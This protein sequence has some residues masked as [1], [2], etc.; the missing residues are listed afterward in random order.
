MEQ[1]AA[2]GEFIALDF[3]TTG[4]SADEHKIIE[5]GAIHVC[6]GRE[7]GRY[8]HLVHPGTP[9]PREITQL[10]GIADA[11]VASAPSMEELR[12]EFAA[13]L[14]DLPI[15]A[16]NATFELSF[17]RQV[18]G[19]D[20]TRPLLDSYELL[21]LMYPQA[22]SHSLEHFS[23]HFGLS[24]EARHRGLNDALD[25]VNVV[26]SA[27]AELAQPGY[28]GLC[29]V[30]NS[31]L[32]DA[33]AW[34]WQPLFADKHP[35]ARLP[36]LRNFKYT[37]GE[38][39]RQP[40]KQDLSSAPEQL[41]KAEFFGRVFAQYEVRP[42]QGVLA[43]RAAE[44]LRDGGVYAAEAGTGIGKTMAY[45]TAALAALARDAESPV[46]ITTHTKSL[47]NQF[48]DRELPRLRELFGLD[49][50]RAVLIKGMNNYACL[51][52]IND[53]VAA[54]RILDTPESRFG[55]AFL[56]HW[57]SVSSEG[58]MDEL[59][60]S[61]YGNSVV[62]DVL[63]GGRALNRDC[64]R[65]Q[66]EF[67]EQCFYFRKRWEAESAHLLMVNHS[68]L[69]IW[70]AA[71]PRF[72]RLIADEA[73]EL[74]RE[75][76]EAYSRSVAHQALREQSTRL[77]DSR[78][79]LPLL[80]ARLQEKSCNDAQFAA[81]ADINEAMP[82]VKR[83]LGEAL[84]EVDNLFS[85]LKRDDIYTLQFA[86]SDQWLNDTQRGAVSECI[87]NLRGAVAAVQKIVKSAIELLGETEESQAA[88]AA[89]AELI[90]RHDEISEAV[91]TL[92]DYLEVDEKRHAAFVRVED[93]DWSVVVAPFNIGEL[94]HER[95]VANMHGLVM[96][97]A[98]LSTRQDMSDV[99]ELCGLNLGE[100]TVKHDRFE[101]P[102][103]YRNNAR[104]VFLKGFPSNN[105]PRFP[106]KAAEFIAQAGLM[107]DGGTLVLFTSKDRLR[108]T[109]DY[110]MPMLMP[111]GIT[112]ISHGITNMS[113]QRCIEQFMNTPRSVLMGARGMWK[114][115]DIPGSK[116]QC[117]M[118]DK[119][120]YAV[121]T[122]YTRGLQANLIRS[123]RE[124]A[125]ERGEEPDERR[126]KS[127]AWNEVDKP[128]M[129]QSFRQ[130]FGRLIRSE[131][132]RGIMVVLDPQLQGPQLSNRHLE[133][134]RLLP[135]MPYKL[136]YSDEALRE[137]EFLLPEF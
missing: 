14:G 8:A 50:L 52:K 116:L 98:T 99:D 125:F 105:T 55:A 114:G 65:Q 131:T 61:L 82:D 100:K 117:V 133:L 60:R 90:Y 76:I 121:P 36:K 83:R 77:F 79:L 81:L 134:V 135:E 69:M 71:Y 101:S 97:S 28:A 120:P 111:H 89:H 70:P 73:D 132:D 130:M 46:V 56:E 75:A 106:Q 104:L 126:M 3:E 27:A 127:R 43:R 5:I 85:S 80:L 30:V 108:R 34:S 10:T 33:P 40:L 26:A 88:T 84:L 45:T 24:V 87:E 118:I 35:D 23:R 95:V 51:R 16:H 47:Q 20:F 62:A 123:Y 44:T 39:E 64:T 107:L 37:Y 109:H 102:F 113:I 66:C 68:L 25:M 119:M 78:G 86:L 32:S 103:D 22:S 129:F 12:D 74:Y 41:N 18:F 92:T 122:P 42:E 19:S 7:R 58:E 67:Y 11:D 31:R 4:L 6:D 9:I 72:T 59:P 128:Q 38:R 53:I 29:A 49:D 15:M 93:Q 94:F 115:V 21:V 96:T 63:Y 2:L 1:L 17:L 137:L 110:L 124:R 112:L 57:T 54:A 91:T 13:F 48:F 136:A